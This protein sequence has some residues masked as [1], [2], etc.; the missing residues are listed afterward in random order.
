MNEISLP[1]FAFSGLYLTLLQ[2]IFY[3]CFQILYCFVSPLGAL[4]SFK[5]LFSI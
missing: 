2:S 5:I 4:S 3:F 1:L